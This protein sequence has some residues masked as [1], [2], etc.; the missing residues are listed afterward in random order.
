VVCGAAWFQVLECLQWLGL[1]SA[2]WGWP[3]DAPRDTKFW[4][5]CVRAGFLLR[6]FDNTGGKWGGATYLVDLS[7]DFTACNAEKGFGILVR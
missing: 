4:L 2:T 1:C 5:L 3:L 6:C 7:Y